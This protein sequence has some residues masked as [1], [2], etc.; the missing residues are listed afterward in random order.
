VRLAKNK[1]DNG[2]YA[3]KII[4]KDVMSRRQMGKEGTFL[5]DVKREIAIMK[6][7][8]CNAQR[9]ACVPMRG[10]ALLIQGSVCDDVALVTR[11]THQASVPPD[12][13]PLPADY[14]CFH[15]QL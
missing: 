12:A 13:M 9:C 6:K 4:N 7:V 1:V 10:C 5:D 11:D 14:R 3:V 15:A 2:L 8:G